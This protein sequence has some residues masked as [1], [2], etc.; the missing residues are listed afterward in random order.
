MAPNGNRPIIGLTTYRQSVPGPISEM[1]GLRPAY[2]EAVLAAGGIPLMLP[3]GLATED[4]QAVLAR[5]DGLLIPGGGDLDTSYYNH[6]PHPKLKGVDLQRDALEIA[7]LQQITQ[8]EKPFLAICR[9][10]QILNVA[11]GGTLWEDLSEQ[12][13]NAIEHDYYRTHPNN[14]KAHEVE[15]SPSSQLA[16]YVGAGSLAVNSLHH[17]GIREL[18]NRLQVTAVAADGLI[19]AIEIQDHPFAIGVQWHPENMFKESPQMRAL[20]QGFITAA[21]NNH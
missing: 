5:L 15:V 2:I 12:L 9:G 10:Y 3:L 13:P 16:H 19:E 11:L 6:P 8:T 4:L 17:Q 21:S 7:I 14:Y 1:I 20:F 18:G